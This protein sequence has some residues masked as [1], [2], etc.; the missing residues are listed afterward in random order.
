MR[1]LL[2]LNQGLPSNV[3]RHRINL[4]RSSYTRVRLRPLRMMYQ[5]LLRGRG[6]TARLRS[7]GAGGH[8]SARPAATAPYRDNAER[9]AGEDRETAAQDTN[10][11]DEQE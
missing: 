10:E 1:K 8:A 9:V 2:W 11:P 6:R 3:A 4:R 5:L 7:A